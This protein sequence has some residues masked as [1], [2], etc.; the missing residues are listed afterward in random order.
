MKRILALILATAMLLT[1]AAC[2]GSGTPKDS[3]PKPIPNVM[4]I[5]HGSAKTVLEDAGFTVIEVE[6]DAAVILDTAPGSHRRTVKTGQVFKVNDSTDPTYR[7]GEYYAPVAVDNKI[8]IYYAAEDYTYVEQPEEDEDFDD[9]DETDALAPG[10]HVISGFDPDTNQTLSLAGFE[11]QFPAYYDVLSEDSTDRYKCYYPEE[12]YYFSCVFFTYEHVENWTQEIFDDWLSAF[13]ADPTRISE[14]YEATELGEEDE[15]L[16]AERV[17]IA[18]LP[19]WVFIYADYRQDN[20]DYIAY[21]LT[22]DA[23]NKNV[24]RIVTIYESHDTSNYDYLGDFEKIVATATLSDG[25]TAPASS[26]SSSSG[27]WREYLAGY[28]AWVD[29]YVEFMQKYQE[30]PS[31]M[32]LLMDYLEMLET[33]TEWADTV[34]E[35]EDDLD[36]PAELAEFTKEYLRILGKMTSGIL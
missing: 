4:G 14:L 9:Y 15:I 1:M 20:D 23:D 30:N 13:E 12:T 34:G 25:A 26:S 3:S 33:M 29:E 22:F 28:E 2:G 11:F 8:T 19:G 21:A 6:A 31:D 36:D 32:T 35:I 24:I 27:G 7:D 5:E 17:T 10:E 18:G 16:K